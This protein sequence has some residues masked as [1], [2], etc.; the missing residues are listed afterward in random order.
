MTADTTGH[1]KARILLV[2]LSITFLIYLPIS[3]KTTVLVMLKTLPKH[4]FF[5]NLQIIVMKIL[6]HIENYKKHTDN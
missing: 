3:E 2:L 4:L 1:I 5:I 6:K